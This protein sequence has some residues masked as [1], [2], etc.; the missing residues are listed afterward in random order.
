[1]GTNQGFENWEQRIY[2]FVYC[3]REF[4]FE[5]TPD[6]NEL[7]RAH[8][9]HT[10]IES[11]DYDSLGMK[12]STEVKANVLM[13][14][15]FR[16][17]LPSDTIIIHKCKDLLKSISFFKIWYGKNKEYVQGFREGTIKN[18]YEIMYPLLER[19]EQTIYNVHPELRESDVD[20]QNKK[21][22]PDVSEA[23]RI[24]NRFDTYLDDESRK[25]MGK[26]N[27][28]SLR[29][30]VTA[31]IDSTL[32]DSA[33]NLARAQLTRYV[34][35]VHDKTALQYAEHYVQ[36]KFRDKKLKIS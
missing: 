20:V 8:L 25:E 9:Y 16:A 6:G 2:L 12:Y 1:M 34:K 17:S 15:T 30:I 28:K 4:R 21:W 36:Q 11:L 19:T 13:L 22:Q 35:S 24:L 32:K 27:P 3:V 5:H 33:I 23:R 18:S 7:L 10:A 31:A 26:R 29:T 14:D